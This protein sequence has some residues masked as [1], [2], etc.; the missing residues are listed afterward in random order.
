MEPEDACDRRDSPVASNADA[1]LLR[2]QEE[3]L[4]GLS[5]GRET[6]PS[7][8]TAPRVGRSPQDGSPRRSRFRCRTGMRWHMPT[9]AL[10]AAGG[11]LAAREPVATPEPTLRRGTRAFRDSGRSVRVSRGGRRAG[12]VDPSLVGA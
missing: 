9:D 12:P 4:I 10:C 2:R 7:L 11:A 8:V 3:V 1:L 6:V 5:I